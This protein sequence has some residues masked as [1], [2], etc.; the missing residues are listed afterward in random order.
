ML[1]TKYV[2]PAVVTLPLTIIVVQDSGQKH[3]VYKICY[4]SSSDTARDNNCCS[5]QRTKACCLQNMLPQQ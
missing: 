4:P 5:G 1:F 3:V 2:T